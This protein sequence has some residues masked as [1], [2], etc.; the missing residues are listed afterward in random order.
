MGIYI[1]EDDETMIEILQDVIEDHELGDVVGYTT[2]GMKDPEEIIHASPDIILVDFLMPGRD[3][4][5]IV[6]ALKAGGS[7]AK[8]IMISQVSSKDM[9]GKAYD[10]GIDFFIS[11]PINIIEVRSVISTV[12]QQIRNERTIAHL[13]NMFLTELGEGLPEFGQTR[14]TPAPQTEQFTR[15][16]ER[17]SVPAGTSKPSAGEMSAYSGASGNQEEDRFYKAVGSI[18][19][20]IGMSGEKGSADILQICVYMHSTG[21]SM[22]RENIRQICSRFTDA[23]KSMEQR[24]RRAIAMGLTNLAHLGIEDFMNDIFA[25][26]A[27]ALFPFEEVRAEMDFIRGKREYG[28]KTS[29]KKFI[30]SLM[31]A[32]EREVEI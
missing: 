1:I 15:R 18:L 29:I 23:P 8:F 24:M 31:F 13:R 28:G 19:G 4:A 12:S 30:E 6:K 16:E 20:K 7:T 11:K 27:S 14:G 2:D 21:K 9:I 32:A 25:E 10:A 5:E 3:G 26:Y 17:K 22:N